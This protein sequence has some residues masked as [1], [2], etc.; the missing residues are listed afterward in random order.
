MA[1]LTTTHHEGIIA[2]A[3]LS[4]DAQ[5]YSDAAYSNNTKKSYA[6][7]LVIFASA[8]Y[9]LPATDR[10]L[11]DFIVGLRKHDGS[12]YSAQSI[13]QCL[14]AIEKAHKLAGFQSPTKSPLVDSVIKGFKRVHGTKATRQAAPITRDR[15][16]E[17]IT[18]KTNSLK[19]KRDKALILLG[20]FGAFRR[21][22]LA[23]LNLNDVQFDNNGVVVTLQKSKTNQEGK[24]EQKTIPARSDKLCPVKALK[25]WIDAAHLVDGRLFRGVTRHGG[26]G[27]SITT[28]SIS[29]I[30][31][32]LFERKT[33]CS[34]ILSISAHS[35]RVGFITTCA[36]A[37]VPTA[38][39][40]SVTGHKTPAMI[41]H[42]TRVIDGF[43]SYP[44]I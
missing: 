28:N 23:T 38:K 29:I 13:N 44:E 42:Y 3:N 12:Q 34:G 25:D 20:F 17:S 1:S 8:G 21:S 41:A 6:R 11:V 14:A 43:D 24:L 22:E 31:K 37:K 7:W 5:H 36:L 10:Q 16:V 35:L 19:A 15:L 2:T 33:D 39:I 27:E 32:E 4:V 18:I 26:I 30:I 40:Q 9:S